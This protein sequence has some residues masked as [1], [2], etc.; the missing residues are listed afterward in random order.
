MLSSKQMGVST[1]KTRAEIREGV[2]SIEISI[3]PRRNWFDI[4][5]LAGWLFFWCMGEVSA[6][7]TVLNDAGQS[8]SS[9][10]LI[11]W[12]IVWTCGGLYFLLVFLF[13]LFGKET[14]SADNEQITL[15]REVFGVGIYS[16]Y[17]TKDITNLTIK[18]NVERNRLQQS[19]YLIKGGLIEFHSRKKT[20]SFASGVDKLEAAS[21]VELIKRRL[22]NLG[23]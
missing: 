19:R 1:F 20:I 7:Y 14:I 8:F 9:W 6:I 15:G 5:F 4:F 23:Q 10:F 16:A 22:P 21:V 18:T 17:S 13:L 11:F 12:L 2:S 3:P